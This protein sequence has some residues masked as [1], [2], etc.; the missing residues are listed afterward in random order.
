MLRLP[1]ELKLQFQN[2]LED[3]Y[4]LKAKHVMNVLRDMR[5]G[6]DYV[7]TYGERM[8]G[9]GQYAELI[10]QRFKLAIKKN[11]LDK[12]DTEFETSLFRV[13]PSSGDQIN[14]F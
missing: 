2:W 9:R 8:K 4:P 13:P 5:G 12:P 11:K 7:A 10:A 3:H 6:K 14:L 1:H